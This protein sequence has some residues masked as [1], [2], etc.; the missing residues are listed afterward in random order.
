MTAALKY[1]VSW[2]LPGVLT[3]VIAACGIAG[4]PLAVAQELKIFR[5]GI[6]YMIN[7]PLKI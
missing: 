7:I 4:I 1:L 5:S 3:V 6:F 2:V